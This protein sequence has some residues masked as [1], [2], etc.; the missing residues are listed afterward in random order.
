LPNEHVAVSPSR[1]DVAEPVESA[2]H[3]D[4]YDYEPKY[5]HLVLVLVVATGHLNSDP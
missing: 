2:N 5:R 1:R 3:A 4:Y